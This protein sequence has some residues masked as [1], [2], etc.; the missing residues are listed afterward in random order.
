MPSRTTSATSRRSRSDAPRVATFM[1]A[2]RRWCSVNARLG[3]NRTTGLRCLHIR[4]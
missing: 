2:V 3:R 4:R 1:A